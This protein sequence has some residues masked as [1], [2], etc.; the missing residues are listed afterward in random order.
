[1]L[2]AQPLLAAVQPHL[3]ILPVLPLINAALLGWRKLLDCVVAGG[4]ETVCANRRSRSSLES[5]KESLEAALRRW[6]TA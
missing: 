5:N 2:P 4:L 3:T 1:M 6:Q